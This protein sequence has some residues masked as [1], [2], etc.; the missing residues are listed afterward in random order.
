MALPPVPHHELDE[1]I[2]AM[3]APD[4]RA[5]A[6]RHVFVAG[7]TGFLGCWLLELLLRANERLDLGMRLTVLSR[8]P[9]AF[10][11]KVP[12]LAN[13]PR[14]SLV[15]GDLR[16]G[17]PQDL[18]CDLLVHAAADVEN[19]EAD[20]VKAFDA[21]VEA[22]RGAL[23]IA[24][25]A[26]ASRVLH[27]SSGAVY[28][29][30]PP[31]LERIAEDHP[32]A[33]DGGDPRAAYGLGKRVSEWLAEQA[34]RAHGFEVVHARVFA[35]LGAYLP[36]NAHFAAGNFLGDAVA[37]RAVQVGGNGA[38]LRSYLYGADAAAWLVT[39]L[40][41]GRAGTAYNVGSEEAINILDL[42]RRIAALRGVDVRIADPRPLHGAPPRYVPDTRLARESLGLVQYTSLATSLERSLRWAEHVAAPAGASGCP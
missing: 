25:R 12:H 26:G 31:T 17:V 38:P 36:L 18:R 30:Q 4:W 10:R 40:V 33:P 5:L 9:Q 19:A 6:G 23:A 20:P 8:R 21:I 28:G 11:D 2:A 13:A 42:A 34:A 35:L 24:Q 32:C 16:E 14:V 3:A 27:V 39:L 37:G 22:T 41:R 15:A 7:G 1:T 29:T